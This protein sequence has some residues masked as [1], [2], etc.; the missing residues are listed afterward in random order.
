M[1][2]KTGNLKEWEL[3][4]RKKEKTEEE[5]ER[6]ERDVGEKREEEAKRDKKKIG[7]PTKGEIL[8]KETANSLPI[9]ELF[10]KGEKKKKRQE[11]K[12][13]KQLKAFKKST[14]VER[15]PIRKK[16]GGWEDIVREMRTRFKDLMRKMK[17][18]R[19]SKKE[20]RR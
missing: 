17:G 10:K 9:V 5:Q 1:A 2:D 6:G 14:K 18:L 3:K 12:E 4:I 8:I 16:K 19:E 15:S 13:V 20:I 11:E 7:R